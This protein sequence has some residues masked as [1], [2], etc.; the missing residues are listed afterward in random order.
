[1]GQNPLTRLSEAEA[2]HARGRLR[3]AGYESEDDGPGITSARP[4]AASASTPAVAARPPEV[5]GTPPEVAGSPPAVVASTPEVTAPQA[6]V[7]VA[8]PQAQSDP[9]QVLETPATPEREMGD[10]SDPHDRCRHCGDTRYHHSLCDPP[11]LESGVQVGTCPGFESLGPS[12][13]TSQYRRYLER[14]GSVQISPE[15]AEPWVLEAG[16]LSTEQSEDITRSRGNETWDDLA[17][18]LRADEVEEQQRRERS[19]SSLEAAIETPAM[20]TPTST[21]PTPSPPGLY[22][23]YIPS[24]QLGATY[25]ANRGFTSHTSVS[26]IGDMVNQRLTAASCNFGNRNGMYPDPVDVAVLADQVVA[27]SPFGPRHRDLEA[28]P[29]SRLFQSTC[30]FR[31]RGATRCNAW[32]VSASRHAVL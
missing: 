22:G 12:I 13:E 10:G 23:G 9:V 8:A 4:S 5:T 17:Q 3:E 28:T 16:D 7:A 20:D 6:A 29:R 24:M 27:M 2:A 30:L 1:M 32:D 14:S 31:S 15:L 25:P 21:P 19:W 11:I 26:A 18:R